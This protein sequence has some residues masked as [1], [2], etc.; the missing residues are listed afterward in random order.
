MLGL[1]KLWFWNIGGKCSSL[2]HCGRHCRGSTLNNQITYHLWQWNVLGTASFSRSQGPRFSQAQQPIRLASLRQA[3]F[4]SQ[5]CGKE[6]CDWH[7]FQLP[8]S[9]PQMPITAGL[10]RGGLWHRARQAQ[11]HVSRPIERSLHYLGTINRR[12]ENKI[13]NR[14][15]KLSLINVNRIIW[16]GCLQMQATE[17]MNQRPLPVLYSSVIEL[18]K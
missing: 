4:H 2:K 3:S 11:T 12:R 5:W 10:N 9:L 6:W 8:L 18:Q 1:L 17:R 13:Q 7:K 16:Y 14:V 15:V